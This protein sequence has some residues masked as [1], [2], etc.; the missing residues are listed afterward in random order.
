MNNPR[1]P[2]GRWKHDPRSRKF[3]HHQ[4]FGTV[5]PQNLPSTLRRPLRS[6]E[7]QQQTVRCTGYGSAVN[8]GYIHARRFSPDW[9]AGKI[10]QVQGVNVDVS[11]GD[12]NATMKAQC[13][14]GYLPIENAPLSLEKDGL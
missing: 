7:D 1:F 6:V 9:Q 10:G 4:F 12:P 5:A 8:G 2:K 3:S 13:D 11:G 14:Y